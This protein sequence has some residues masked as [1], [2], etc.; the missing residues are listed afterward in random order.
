RHFTQEVLPVLTPVGLDPA[1]PFPRILNKSLNL[2]LTLE[3]ADAFGR[4]ARLAVVQ[5]PRSL[6]RLIRMPPSVA[7]QPFDFVLLSA[8]IQAHVGPVFPGMK[9]TSPHEFRVTRDSDLWVDEE[10]IDD[11][12]Q[13]LKGELTRRHYGIAVRLEVTSA[14]P[15]ET[16]NFLLEQFQLGAD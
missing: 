10:E 4:S 14:C 5:V 16:I 12:L 1:H 13:A 3:G 15:Q 8:L 9:V 6:P 2:I 11:L 7:G